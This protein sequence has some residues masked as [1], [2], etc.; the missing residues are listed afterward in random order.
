MQPQSIEHRVERAAILL[1]ADTQAIESADAQ[2]S[3]TC[4]VQTISNLLVLVHTT[5]ETA[6]QELTSPA[7]PSRRLVVEAT[8]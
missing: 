6:L 5:A 8:P 3:A 1:T 2:L 7:L 4:N